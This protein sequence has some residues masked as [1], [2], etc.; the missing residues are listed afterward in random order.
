M[1]VQARQGSRDRADYLRAISELLWPAP[2]RA[3]LAVRPRLAAPADVSMIVLPGLRDPRLVVPAGRRPA[4]A[5][6]RPL[7]GVRVGP[8]PPHAGGT[9]T[10]VGG[11]GA[12]RTSGVTG[13]T[14]R[15]YDRPVPA[16]GRTGP[17]GHDLAEERPG[18][19][20][21]FTTATTHVAGLRVGSGRGALA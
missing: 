15:R 6:V 10:W 4:A 17:R 11:R 9:P 7:P 18:D 8:P 19:L 14:G 3:E 16:T 5:A 21:D 20:A 13:G 12:S 2:A 1:T